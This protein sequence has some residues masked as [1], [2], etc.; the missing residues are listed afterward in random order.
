MVISDDQ[1]ERLF[2]ALFGLFG[3]RPLPNLVKIRSA[4]FGLSSSPQKLKIEF[5]EGGNEIRSS[6]ANWRP[7]FRPIFAFPRKPAKN[8]KPNYIRCLVIR[9]SA[10]MADFRIS[11]DPSDRASAENLRFFLRSGRKLPEGRRCEIVAFSDGFAAF[12]RL[13]DKSRFCAICL[14]RCI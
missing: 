9:K 14:R 11:T 2:D 8:Q 1:K 10:K 4:N 5:F 13:A 3:R 7:V 6:G 12:G